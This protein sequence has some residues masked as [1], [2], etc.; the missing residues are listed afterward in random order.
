MDSC[1]AGSPSGLGLG[2]P[3]AQAVS[4]DQES[5]VSV[6]EFFSVKSGPFTMGS[7]DPDSN[8]LD[9]EG[10]LRT[11]DLPKFE[12]ATT[13]V[14][15]RQFRDFVAATGYQ[16]EAESAGWSFVF[17]LLVEDSVDVLGSSDRA[18]WWLGIHNA[19]WHR[20]VGKE[21]DLSSLL[22]HPVVHVSFAD[23]I[24]YCNWS[25][26]RLPSESEWEKAARGGLESA[27]Y[28]WGDELLVDDKW[29]CNIFQ[30]S[31][32]DLNTSEDGFIGTS[33]VKTY[34]A[35]GYGGYDFAGN[36]WEW[37]SSDFD[38][39]STQL[40]GSELR[41]TRGGSYLC[42]D[43]YCNRYRVGARNRTPA[44]SLAGNIGFRVV[45][46]RLE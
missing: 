24:A 6:Q 17:R 42:H 1:C 16:T 7:E 19:N 20:P 33:P 39:N 8:P 13:P 44:D 26:T 34:P 43:S 2:L 29:Q 21:Q 14:T 35:N 45:R 40:T 25:D 30:G 27:R 32:P 18:P 15:N 31:F 12:I 11:V 38:D 23:A 41:V 4:P 10:P 22:D 9:F 28:P 3:Q 46:G 36:V 5:S 37:T